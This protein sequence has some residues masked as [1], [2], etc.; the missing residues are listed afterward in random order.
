MVRIFAVS[1]FKDS[2]KTTLCR[3]LIYELSSMG[4]KTGYVK[5]TSEDVFE[6][7]STD[8]A[9]VRDA[10][11]RSVLWGHDGIRAEE[12]ADAVFD[13]DRI[14]SNYF[15]DADIVIVEGGK[16][17]DLPKIWV[18][19]NEPHGSDVTGI[20]MTYDRNK[21]SD[22]ICRFTKGD[23]RKMAEK[24][25]QSVIG[26]NYRSAA[27]FIN[28]RQLPMKNFIADFIR[29]SIIGMISSLKGA[30]ASDRIKIFVK[31]DRDS[32]SR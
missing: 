23:E 13:I 29:G 2:G 21:P 11:I 31:H 28:D 22:G 17:L 1:G 3:R 10:G 25:A 8:T 19:N 18:E 12:R 20:F 4:I 5:R 7:R 9:F 30:D 14:V 32:R 24:L 6:D 26:D 27:V 16:H 15:P